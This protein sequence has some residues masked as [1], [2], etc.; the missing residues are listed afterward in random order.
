MARLE[1]FRDP[2]VFRRD[3]L[4]TV[5]GKLEGT[6]EVKVGDYPYRHPVVAVTAHELWQGWPERAPQRDRFYRYDYFHDPFIFGSPWPAR[7]LHRW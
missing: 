7:R 3:R 4:I 5:V 6:R 2:M 1:G